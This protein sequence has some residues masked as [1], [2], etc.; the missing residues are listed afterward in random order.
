M[1]QDGHH[2]SVVVDIVPRG[3]GKAANLFLV[4]HGFDD[5][6]AVWCPVWRPSDEQQYRDQRRFHYPLAPPF[7]PE[8]RERL[9][10][11]PKGQHELE[12]WIQINHA[13]CF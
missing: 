11:H 6:P 13:L 9:C 8:Q 7:L 4:G 12:R 3:D 2:G 1:G 5:L 10:V